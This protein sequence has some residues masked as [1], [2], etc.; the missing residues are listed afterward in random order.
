MGFR[1]VT[2]DMDGL[3]VSSVDAK[4]LTKL[5]VLTVGNTIHRPGNEIQNDNQRLVEDEFLQVLLDK[6]YSLVS[7][8]DIASVVKEQQFQKSGLTEDN[9]RQ[10]GKLLNVPAVLVVRITE[11][12]AENQRSAELPKQ[13]LMGRVS[14]EARLV[15]VETG[16]TTWTLSQ[17]GSH[18]LTG[19]SELSTLLSRVARK[20]ATSFPDKN[21]VPEKGTTEQGQPSSASSVK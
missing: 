10:L 1:E 20:L 18:M 17:D 14:L 5:A 15:S 9:A 4:S 19:R 6:G 8:S 11:C 16:R 21:G 7:R 2:S 13:I 12:T 3:P